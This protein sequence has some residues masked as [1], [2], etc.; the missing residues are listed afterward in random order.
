MTAEGLLADDP[1]YLFSLW[2]VSTL[3]AFSITLAFVSL[4]YTIGRVVS[5][6]VCGSK[7]PPRTLYNI[8][9]WV[10]REYCSGLYHQ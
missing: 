2:C 5:P 8:T 7:A 1:Q 4:W 10:K 9:Y 6:C 3:Y